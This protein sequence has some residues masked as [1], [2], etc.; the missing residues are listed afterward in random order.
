MVD[1]LP[2]G[3]DGRPDRDAL[4]ETYEMVDVLVKLYETKPTATLAKKIP[5]EIEA[6]RRMAQ[7]SAAWVITEIG[8]LDDRFKTAHREA[9][10]KIYP[11]KHK[12]YLHSGKE[13]GMEDAEELGFARDSDAY[14]NFCRLGYEVTFDILVNEDGT[15]QATHVNGV[16]LTT[17][18]DI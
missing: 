15:A 10:K 13:D 11:I 8:K 2:G 14:D 16:A 4:G 18:V 12:L 5:K 6:L 7:G 9:T 3:F 1:S 17:P